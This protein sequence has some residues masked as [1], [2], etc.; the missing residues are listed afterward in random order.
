MSRSPTTPLARATDRLAGV[1]ATRDA[2]RR[3]YEAY[4]VA[5]GTRAVV[6]TCNGGKLAWVHRRAA[7]RTG[8]LPLA[9]V[10]WTAQRSPS[11]LLEGL[12]IRDGRQQISLLY[13]EE[14]RVAER[15]REERYPGR[16][17]ELGRVIGSAAEGLAASAAFVAG[18]GDEHHGPGR[19]HYP[20]AV[21][22]G[23][24]LAWRIGLMGCRRALHDGR[25]PDSARYL[26][27]DG[28]EGVAVGWGASRE[29]A[30]AAYAALVARALPERRHTVETAT[31]DYD[32]DGNLIARGELPPGFGDPAPPGEA[33]SSVWPLEPEEGESWKGGR[34]SE[35]GGDPLPPGGDP[36]TGRIDTGPMVLRGPSS[37]A[38]DPPRRA[39][40]VPHVLIQLDPVLDAPS[41]RGRWV[42][43]LGETGVTRHAL[44]IEERDG[45]LLVG[46]DILGLVD[47]ARLRAD[48]D[49][50]E[51][52]DPASIGRPE[53]ERFTRFR[54][55]LLR[56][57]PATADRPE[58]WAS[59][60]QVSGPRF[61]AGGLDGDV[62]QAMVYRHRRVRR[63]GA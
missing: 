8:V 57:R 29:E 14:G 45:F 54:A 7:D 28:L 22:G 25:V 50:L 27:A 49:A 11:R 1:L 26:V 2:A 60:A 63:S 16:L 36:V 31:D 61:D 6:D 35:S 33:A 34:G 3:W 23:V 55:R 39:E 58:G 43:L 9:S 51:A 48:L 52:R 37:D 20:V 21:P 24:L 46:S 38:P 56:W 59:A 17:V 19:V 10:E 4:L 18:L 5:L 12:V 15:S 47:L 62:L 44:R 13:D 42:R 41:P 40:C 30:E 53:Y 32:D